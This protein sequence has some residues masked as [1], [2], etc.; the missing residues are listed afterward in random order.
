MSKDIFKILLLFLTLVL[1]ACEK[2]EDKVSENTEKQENY[3]RILL[4]AYAK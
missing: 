3:K 4:D 1:F 2:K